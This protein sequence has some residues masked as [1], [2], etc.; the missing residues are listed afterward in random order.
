MRL[1]TLS[2]AVFLFFLKF[3]IAGQ[4][5]QKHKNA[6]KYR[7]NFLQIFFASLAQKFL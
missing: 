5:N 4:Y 1:S 7:Q 3:F 2:T 6:E